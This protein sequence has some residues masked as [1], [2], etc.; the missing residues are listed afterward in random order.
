MHVTQALSGFH[1]QLALNDDV[2]KRFAT[3]MMSFLN[4]FFAW[5]TYDYEF[6]KAVGVGSQLC[7][8]LVASIFDLVH[9]LS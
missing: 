5:M 6:L 4:S 3:D 9:S 2:G 7:L 1:L 8:P